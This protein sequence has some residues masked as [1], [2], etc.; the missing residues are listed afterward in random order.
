MF[1]WSIEKVYLWILFITLIVNLPTNNFFFEQQFFNTEI[2]NYVLIKM[3]FIQSFHVRVS[4][5][6]LVVCIRVTRPEKKSVLT[7]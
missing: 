1:L 2:P 4:G 3:I 7:K 5:L 6:P